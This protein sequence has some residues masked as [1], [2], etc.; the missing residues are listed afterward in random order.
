LI[1]L[2]E[3]EIFVIQLEKFGWLGANWLQTGVW[4]L[5]PFGRRIS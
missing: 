5:D 3:I 4:L 1:K 2:G